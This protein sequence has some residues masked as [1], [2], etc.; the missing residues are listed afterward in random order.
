M[1]KVLKKKK[2]IGKA[3]RHYCPKRGWVTLDEFGEFFKSGLFGFI[4]DSYMFGWAFGG[5]L[6]GAIIG[7]MLNGGET[8]ECLVEDGY[9]LGDGESWTYLEDEP[10][11]GFNTAQ[12]DMDIETSL[13][14]TDEVLS[15]IENNRAEEAVEL[16]I[17][18]PEPVVETYTAPEPVYEAPTYSAPSY[19]SPSYESSSS[20]GGGYDSG[21]S[22]DCGGCD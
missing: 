11:S 19:S 17:Y 20:S 21:G 16:K 7:D 1:R 15:V 18:E 13:P 12:Y 4:T 14:T 9:V 2:N 3:R 5:D 22:S 6:T 8:Y 10:S